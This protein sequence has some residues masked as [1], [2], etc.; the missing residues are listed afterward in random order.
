MV[1]KPRHLA[2]FLSASGAVLSLLLISGCASTPE[3]PEMTETMPMEQPS[4]VVEQPEPDR[5]LVVELKADYPE[6]YVV[7]KGDTLWDISAR[8]LKNPWQWPQ[9]W[10]FNPQVKNPHLIYPGDVLAIY[11]IDG[12]P[13]MQVQRDGKTVSVPMTRAYIDDVPRDVRR[14][15]YPTVKL[16]PRIREEGLEEAIPTIPVDAIKPFLTRPQVVTED[17]LEQAPY[18]VAHADEHMAAGGGYRIYARGINEGE[19]VGDYSLVRSGQTYRD[20]DSGEVLG[21]EAVYL[22][23]ARM[24]RF[25]DPST[26]MVEAANREILRGDRLLPKADN[27]FLQSFMPRGPEQPV[28]GKIIAVFDGVAQIGQYQV[29]V[30]NL[31]SQDDIERGHVLAV[32]QLGKKIK[33]TVEGGSVKLPD[34]RAGEI[35]VFRVFERVSYALV[36]SATKAMHVHDVVSNP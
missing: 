35:M 28:N 36:M 3:E 19:A 29:V 16:S 8:F 27:T 9:L 2:H 11:F 32:S 4:P 6:K 17:E 23:D 18:V 5:A 12:Q 7:V 13:V 1:T 10:Q 33:D 25:G 22:G 15:G 26:L 20:P 31:G 24:Q 34:E 30:L 14:Q 21:Y